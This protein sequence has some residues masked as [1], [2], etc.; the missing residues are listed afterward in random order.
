MVNF[1]TAA[2]CKMLRTARFCSNR[3]L[4]NS[5]VQFEYT[6]RNG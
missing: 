6:E 4:G 5:L 2:K 1:K 3:I